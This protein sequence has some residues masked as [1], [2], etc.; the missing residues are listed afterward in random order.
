MRHLAFYLCI[1]ALLITGL[2]V[3]AQAVEPIEFGDTLEGSLTADTAALE[4]AFEGESGQ[5]VTITMVADNFDAFLRLQD[6]KGSEIA[7][8][9]D[10]AGNLNARIETF[11]LPFND[12][13]TIVATSLSGTAS[14]DFTVSLE[15][16]KVSNI[17][18][19]QII[20]GELTTA[21]TFL[22]YHFTGQAGDAVSIALNSDDFDSFLRLA[23]A[24]NST[25]DLVTNDDG[26][27][28]LN[29]LIGPYTLPETGDYV[30][31]AT[32]LGGDSTGSFTLSLNKV[33]LMTLTIG[34]ETSAE[35][36]S[37]APVYFSFEGKI[38]QALN[39]RVDSDDTIDTTLRLLGPDNYE[40]ASDDDSGGR[41]D[42]EIRSYVLDRD[43]TF[44]ILVSPYSEGEIGEFTITIS[45]IELPSLDAGPQQLRLSDK[46][47]RQV[48]IFTGDADEK[49]RLSFVLN[50]GDATYSPSISLTQAGISLTYMSISM[51]NEV[52]F[53]LTIPDDG[54]VTIQIDDYS[55]TSNVVTAMLERL[56]D[57][58]E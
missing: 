34:E 9:D 37:N 49:V 1:L 51:V 53:V 24:E 15:T 42:P 57:E 13:F 26:G 17:E 46:Q 31:T 56:T 2:S 10:S 44:T 50:D 40:L 32:S 47:T 27:G 16:A 39:I 8:D 20:Q 43:G 18:Y 48:V 21:E 19:T 38:G 36:T 23:S 22:T 52:S 11:K 12:T 30:I 35:L 6:S 55:Y 14:G 41:I 25:I 54:Q 45:E 58:D 5:Y 7:E 4:Y 28:S 29:A 33:E 3:L